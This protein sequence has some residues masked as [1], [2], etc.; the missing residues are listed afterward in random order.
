MAVTHETGS[1]TKTVEPDG[2]PEEIGRISISDIRKDER[3][4]QL[5]KLDAENP[6]FIHSY[7]HPKLSVEEVERKGKEMVLIDGKPANHLGDPVVRQPKE[8]V[9]NKRMREETLS[10]QQLKDVTESERDPRVMRNPK[11][12]G[13]K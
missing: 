4:D 1:K 7:E 5:K 8:A 6:D 2:R 12:P 3:A 9:L 13:Q 11:K 10:Y